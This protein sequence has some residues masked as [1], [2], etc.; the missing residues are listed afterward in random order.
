ML[1]VPLRVRLELIA[2]VPPDSQAFR[3]RLNHSTDF[4]GSPACRE[5]V[6]GL[7]G[8]HNMGANASNKSPHVYLYNPIDSVPLKNPHT[9]PFP[10]WGHKLDKS[11][12]FLS[13]GR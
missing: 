1:L 10:P 13:L 12:P 7:L 6:V 4:P 5:L 9:L 11:F 2:P 3:L 8:L